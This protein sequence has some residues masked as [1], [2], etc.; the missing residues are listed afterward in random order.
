MAS[1]LWSCNLPPS[2]R[3][4]SALRAVTREC[5]APRSVALSD[6]VYGVALLHPWLPY[7]DIMYEFFMYVTCVLFLTVGLL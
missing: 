1:L 3:E 7:G 5:S 4:C 6:L 2:I